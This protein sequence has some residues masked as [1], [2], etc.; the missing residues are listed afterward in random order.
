[1]SVRRILGPAS[2]VLSLVP[3][4]LMKGKLLHLLGPWMCGA[5]SWD[6]GDQLTA[7]HRTREL[8]EPQCLAQ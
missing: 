6:S 4:V 2:W 1:M 8:I 3:P 5:R 7:W